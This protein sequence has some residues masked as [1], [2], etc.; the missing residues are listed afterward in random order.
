MSAGQDG[1]AL[2]V[3]DWNGAIQVA[4]WDIQETGAGDWRA[5]VVN[6]DGDYLENEY[7][8]K[9]ASAIKHA[10]ANPRT[11]APPARDGGDKP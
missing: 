4:G 7:F 11:A 8:E 2:L 10:R 6:A 1:G 9:R 5:S 3:P